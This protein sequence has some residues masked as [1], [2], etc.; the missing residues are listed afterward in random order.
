MF[1]LL[2]KTQI[3]TCNRL[4]LALLPLCLAIST[5]CGSGSATTS[6]IPAMQ[7]TTPLK[8]SPQTLPPAT[9]G[10]PYTTA[11]I[12]SGGIPPYLWSLSSGTLPDGLSLGQNTGIISGMT[13]DTGSF[14]F[15]VTVEDSQGSAS[16]AGRTKFSSSPPVSLPPVNHASAFLYLNVVE[17]ALLTPPVTITSG[18]IPLATIGIPY[19]AALSATGGVPPYAWEISSGSLPDW[20]TLNL[21]T[22]ILTGTPNAVGTTTLTI[23]CTPSGG[24]PVTKVVTLTVTAQISNFDNLYCPTP[25]CTPTWGTYDNTG[26]LPI[27]A[28]NTAI[29][30]TPATLNPVNVS[31]SAQLITALAAAACGQQITLQCGNTFSGHFTIPALQCPANDYLWIQSSCVSSLPAEAARYSMTYTNSQGSQILTA[32]KFGPCYAGVTSLSGRPTF[33]C[34]VAPGIYTAKIS[35]PDASEAI[36]FS[37][38]T[39]SG[40]RI[41]GLEVTRATGTGYVAELVKL[42]N[43][44]TISDVIFDRWWCHGDELQDETESCVN[45]SGIPYF[46]SVD[47]Y[48]GDF[49]CLTHCT[50]AHAIY[51]GLNQLSSTAE[52]P[53]KIVNNFI[54]ASGENVLFGGGSALS[55]PADIEYRGNLNFKPM[56]W[57]AADPAYNGGVG[58]VPYIVKNLFELKNAQR[59]LIEGNMFV[60]SW[61]GFS[62]GGPAWDLTPVN[63][64][65]NAPTAFDANIT[66]RYNWTTST[67][68]AMELDL[69]NNG[70]YL[71]A[72]GNHYSIH[73]DVF[74]NLGYCQPICPT[75]N[76]TVQ[77]TT[78]RQI[79]SAS[80]T[81]HDVTVRNVSFIY[82]PVA[83][84]SAAIGL[85]NPTIASGLNQYNETYTSNLQQTFGGTLNL[86][87]G[88]DP[89]NC[90]NGIPI[91]IPMFAACWTGYTV[92]NNC[93]LDNGSHTWPG[94]NTFDTSYATALT[95]YANGFGG[96]YVVNPR[97]P[98]KAAGTDGLDPGANIAVV[99]AVLAGNPAP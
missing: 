34:P 59:A 31:T 12:V 70:G 3:S 89:T 75:S 36:V 23:Q 65:G 48:Y 92:S 67:N 6:N 1:S 99:A 16:S 79:T 27:V 21:F 19:W 39:T 86:E 73:D 8:I 18:S 33:D 53:Q 28:Y 15:Q 77:M 97:S 42:G 82:A 30:N 41:I 85:S 35:T 74:D 13:T 11:L 24:L 96:D 66:L 49:V 38:G 69:A 29:A 43:V 84:P 58:G 57:R 88:S 81:Q 98:C 71:A 63:Q 54:E 93:F 40:I 64:S 26:E 45:I 83:T 91:G 32:P 80:Q 37:P 55:T 60:G 9:T 51:G 94:T 62:Q 68:F 61:S 52:G 87:G 17:E 25:G 47:S 56:T 76:P 10:S 2:G 22:G 14:A 95:N 90:A 72:G 46:A 50:D 78:A 4:T 20:A 44:G 5:A 7:V